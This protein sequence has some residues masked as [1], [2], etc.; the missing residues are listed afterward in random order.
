MSKSEKINVFLRV[1]PISQIEPLAWKYEEGCIYQDELSVFGFDKVFAD[2]V[3]NREIYEKSVENIVNSALDGINGTIF[4]YG[5]TGS[6]K[7]HTMIGTTFRS[8]RQE[9]SKR[10][11]SRTARNLSR[12]S[13]S[14]IGSLT[15]KSP[16]ISKNS[17]VPMQNFSNLPPKP[18][19]KRQKLMRADTQKPDLS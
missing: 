12:S 16:L 10:S 6:G 19:A 2:D 3:M 1:K 11:V 4:M 18:K 8:E 7:T 9:V 17:Y 13:R 15:P 5:Q 14:R